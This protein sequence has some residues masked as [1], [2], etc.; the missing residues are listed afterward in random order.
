MWNTHQKHTIQSGAKVNFSGAFQSLLPEERQ[1]DE[2][3]QSDEMCH[4]R[5]TMKFNMSRSIDICN[6]EE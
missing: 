3:I 5:L 6:T 2:H 1:H 4:Y